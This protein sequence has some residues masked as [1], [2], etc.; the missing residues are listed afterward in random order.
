MPQ[1][2]DLRRVRAPSIRPA[3]SSQAADPHVPEDVRQEMDTLRGTLG[4]L[5]RDF[6]RGALDQPGYLDAVNQSL[7]RANS[8]T[9]AYAGLPLEVE[10]LDDALATA[11]R[12]RASAVIEEI[13]VAGRGP[14]GGSRRSGGGGRPPLTLAGPEL[15][16][17]PGGFNLDL[18]GSIANIAQAS[19]VDIKIDDTST[20]Q[21]KTKQQVL[22][23]IFGTQVIPALPP[24]R[25][26]GLSGVGSGFSLQSGN[27]ST[28]APIPVAMKLEG[29]H[30][31]M[32]KDAIQNLTGNAFTEDQL[33][34]IVGVVEEDLG[35]LDIFRFLN[36]NA[37]ANP[38][39]LTHKQGARVRDLLGKLPTDLRQT[40]FDKLREQIS[41]G[42]VVCPTCLENGQ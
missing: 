41:I 8:G 29:E 25:R 32:A 2:H 23:E 3:S 36:V 38:L 42:R 27:Q 5:H 26:G 7:A 17:L 21:G 12:E 28:L 13:T 9:L 16:E 31:I 19:G 24:H 4:S 6:R 11:P 14:G 20:E 39:T 15:G 1:P 33:E 34:T 40:A 35:K 18:P 22:G 10:T 37:Y 30:R